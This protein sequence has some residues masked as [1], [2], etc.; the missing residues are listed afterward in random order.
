MIK[1]D[2]IRF[3]HIL[4]SIDLIEEFTKNGFESDDT[5]TASAVFYQL[6][7]IGEAVRH[8]SKEYHERFSDLPWIKMIGLRNFLV[9]EYFSVAMDRIVL[10]L[11]DL[12]HI[13]TR[14]TSIIQ[15]LQNEK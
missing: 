6:T 1:S 11:Q 10:A 2:L 15:E 9:H 13:K 8:I 4:E 5:K 3:K 7:V 14:I 12:P